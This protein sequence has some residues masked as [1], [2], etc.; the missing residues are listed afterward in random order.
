[1]TLPRLTEHLND[2]R[3][4]LA[5]LCAFE[6]ETETKRA[7]FNSHRDKNGLE[8]LELSCSVTFLGNGQRDRKRKTGYSG[9]RAQGKSTIARIVGIVIYR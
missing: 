8:T 6:L 7:S 2:L 1:M 9:S 4:P 5:V 3:A